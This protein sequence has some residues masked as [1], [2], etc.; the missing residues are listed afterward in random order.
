MKSTFDINDKHRKW[1]QHLDQHWV[2]PSCEVFWPS[3]I[4][5]AARQAC[6]NSQKACHGGIL[7]ATWTSN[8][9]QKGLTGG[10]H[11]CV[12]LHFQGKER[13]LE[14]FCALPVTCLIPRGGGGREP[15]FSTKNIFLKMRAS[16]TKERACLCEL[17]FSPVK[18]ILKHQ[19][20]PRG[21]YTRSG[22]LSSR[23]QGTS[24]CLC[25]DSAVPWFIKNNCLLPQRT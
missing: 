10:Y 11:G 9:K 25:L 21:V 13:L 19:N 1:K 7:E 22:E 18:V 3:Y 23:M 16:C 20:V 15:D 5:G 14:S 17:T 6:A 8:P 4:R 24:L 2:K 12:L